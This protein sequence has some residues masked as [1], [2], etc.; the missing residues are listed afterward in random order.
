MKY[1]IGIDNGSQS[2][3]VC[4]YDLNGNIIVEAKQDLK[5]YELPKPGHVLHPDDDI[6]DSIC[7]SCN[8]MM[9]RFTG[10]V[11]DIIGV[12]LCT[13]RCCRALMKEDGN[14]AYPVQSWM[15]IRLSQ[16]YDH[17]IKDVAYVTTSSGY[18]THRLTGETKDTAGNYVGPW[19]IDYN[20]WDWLEKSEEFDKYEL[21]RDMLFDLV[22][23]NDLL[24]TISSK[25]SKLTSLPEGLKVFASSNDKSVEALGAGLLRDNSMLL[26]LGTYICCMMQG[27]GIYPNSQNF[28][29]NFSDLPGK[30]LYETTGIR[31]G[32]WTVSWVR[33]LI[34]DHGLI[35]VEQI[36]GSFEV[37]LNEEAKSV[38]AGCDGLLTL[39]DFLA[40]TH[41]PYKKGVLI[42]LDA[43]HTRAHIYK[44]VFEAIAMTM[45]IHS[46]K[47]TD[48]LKLKPNKIIVTGGG[49]NSELFMQIIADVNGIT[50]VRNE[51]NGCASLGAAINCAIGL[52]VY[53][54]FAY[55]TEAMVRVKDEFK[56]NMENHKLY[57]RVISEVYE[58]LFEHNNELLLKIHNI[59]D[60]EIDE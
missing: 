28:W 33:D 29:T 30:Y 31:R 59:F 12:G 27:E 60:K 39:L 3:K 55:A 11:N 1:I 22:K 47:M 56:P 10:D 35:D 23:P 41:Q 51:V 14:L 9:N 25:A 20:K 52:G 44:S 6:W 54:N 50:S 32:M 53:E 15:D 48:E 37:F 26:S 4:M 40:P 36:G 24:G 46:E 7:V 43:R 8:E 16:N 42:G 5:P 2:S 58:D 18:I 49:S 17:S 45:N 21:P 57:K 19:P 13:I 34:F 38:P